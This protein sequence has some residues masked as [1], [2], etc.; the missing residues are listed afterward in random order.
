MSYLSF[1]SILLP[2]FVFLYNL[3]D[4]KG[5]WTGILFFY[6]IFSFLS[7]LG[8]K[9]LPPD[10]GLKNISFSVFTVAEYLFFATYLYRIIRSESAKK[11]LIVLS[12]SYV[13]FAILFVVLNFKEH[14][15]NSIS[16]AL[17]ALI[18]IS[19]CIFFLFEQISKP[20]SIFLYNEKAFWVVCGLLIYMAG[21][22]FL[23]LQSASF[24]NEE[25][26]KYW[27]I[28]QIGNIIKNLLFAV[29]FYI[30]PNKNTRDDFLSL[31]KMYEI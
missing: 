29:A 22:F 6:L 18:I 2:V 12:I 1:I 31:G 11:L 24:S 15:F 14:D 17:E 23:F 3:K 4:N 13:F 27:I 20:N 19:F 26:V 5:T 30:K 8:N 28:S 7:D 9:L 21:T 25:L 10:I 16:A